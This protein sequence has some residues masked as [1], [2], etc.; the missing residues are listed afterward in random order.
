[1][2][3]VVQGLIGA[4]RLIVTADREVLRI[5][6]LTLRVSLVA[7]GLAL[8]VGI[9]LGAWMA[10]FDFPGRRLAIGWINAMMGLPPVVVGLWVSIMLWRYGPLGFLHLMFTPSA[11]VIAQFIICTP[12]ATGVTMA[13]V[14]QVNPKL[15]EQLVSLGATRKQLLWLV[16]RE[17]RMSVVAAAIAGFGRAVS[18]VGA[19]MMVGGNIMGYTRVLTTAISME[20]SRGEFQMALALSFIL[21][22]LSY[23]A[24]LGL[25]ILQQGRKRNGRVSKSRES[26]VLL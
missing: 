9:P 25:T 21:L 20:V 3:L 18:E 7:T 24:S 4:I 13:G 26:N 12:V 5:T 11:I 15:L 17:S 6:T 8:V 1:M 14:Q 22:A 19:S 23:G 2:E 16:L 10:L